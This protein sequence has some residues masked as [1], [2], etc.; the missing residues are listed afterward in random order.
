MQRG[1]VVAAVLLGI[2]GVGFGAWRL[3][4]AIEH[5][6]SSTS[7]TFTLATPAPDPACAVPENSYS[8][9]CNQN[10]CNPTTVYYQPAN[11]GCQPPAAITTTISAAP[12]P[13]RHRKH[14]SKTPATVRPPPSGPVSP[15]TLGRTVRKQ[16]VLFASVRPDSLTC[17]PLSRRKG[18]AVTCHVTGRSLQNGMAAVRGTA[19]VTM[20][21]GA[22]DRAGVSFVFTGAGG[23]Q[24]NGSGYPFDPDTGRV[25]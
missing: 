14:R 1:R 5:A 22:G 11:P 12:P 20:E 2:L 9:D 7:Q 6:T 8:S 16:L 17:P 19:R 18:A 4:A 3:V 21:D 25:L 23:L 15:Q 13:G 24:I 10:P